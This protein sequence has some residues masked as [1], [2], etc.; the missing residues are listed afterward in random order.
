AGT[1]RAAPAAV[2]APARAPVAARALVLRRATDGASLTFRPGRPLVVGR[3]NGCDLVVRSSAAS[4]RHTLLDCHADGH[5]YA[6]DLGS[7]AGRRL[8]NALIRGRAR[9][10]AGME[11]RFA[12]EAWVVGLRG[13]STARQVGRFVLEARIWEGSHGKLFRARDPG[14]GNRVVALRVY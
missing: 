5:W 10:S 3:D 8:D 1:R 9:L 12:D 13:G 7:A 4:S 2:P 11:I 14:K 6:Y